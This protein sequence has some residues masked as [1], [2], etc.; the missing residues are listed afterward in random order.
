MSNASGLNQNYNFYYAIMQRVYTG[1]IFGGKKIYQR[2]TS[3]SHLGQT[4]LLYIYIID[5]YIIDNRLFLSTRLG[6]FL[7]RW[8]CLLLLP[9]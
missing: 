4:I 3:G 9:H 7:V 6:C 5:I 2:M 1:V 8:K